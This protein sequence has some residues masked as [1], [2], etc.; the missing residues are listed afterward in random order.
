LELFT[1]EETWSMIEF[2]HAH[3]PQLPIKA[4]K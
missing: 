2:R 4:Q 3:C 1:P